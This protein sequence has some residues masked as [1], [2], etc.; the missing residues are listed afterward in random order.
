MLLNIDDILFVSHRRLFP[1]EEPRFFVGRV[2]TTEHELIKLEGFSFVR[3]LSS[4]QVIRKDE[5]RIK[6]LSL[7]SVGFFFYQLPVVEDVSNMRVQ[8]GAGELLLMDGDR[9]LMNLSEQS[10]SGH[11]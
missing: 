10:H 6:I 5:K 1:H 11:F 8:D 2:I 9:M 7:A 3:D 4:G